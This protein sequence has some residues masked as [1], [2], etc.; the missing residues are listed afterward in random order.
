MENK[1]ASLL[2]VLLGKALSWPSGWCIG[3][4]NWLRGFDAQLGHLYDACTSLPQ[5][6]QAATKWLEIRKKKKKK[7][8]PLSWCGG[9]MAG[10]F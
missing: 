4:R 9:R 3:L 2:V 1:Q 5:K 6:S 7:G 8:I 10:S